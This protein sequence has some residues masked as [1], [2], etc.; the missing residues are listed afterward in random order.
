MKVLK[1]TLSLCPVCLKEI[2]ATVYEREDGIYIKK[3]CDEGHG[4]WDVM[5]EPCKDYYKRTM[6]T[7]F[8]H[9][10]PPHFTMGIP[11]THECN[12]KCPFCYAPDRDTKYDLSRDKI[13]EIIRTF[14]GKHVTLTGGEPTMNPHLPEF[15][16]ATRDAGLDNCLVSNGVKLADKAYLQTLIDAGMVDILFPMYGFDDEIYK[17]MTGRALLQNRLTV[18]QNLID[19]DMPICLSFTFVRGRN[20]EQFPKVLEYALKNSDHVHQIR[21]RSV[22]PGGACGS[23]NPFFISEYLDVISKAFDVTP[24]EMIDFSLGEGPYYKY[25]F[26]ESYKAPRTPI[27]FELQI[28]N[29]MRDRAANGNKRCQELLDLMPKKNN[30]DPNFRRRPEVFFIN[31][32]H[33]GSLETVDLMNFRNMIISLYSYNKGEMNFLEATLLSGRGVDL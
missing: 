20:E 17:E 11:I 4:K 23:E 28:I 15:I 22:S 24:Q 33:W 6:Q 13:L 12:L 30:D 32:W 19:A 18:L 10:D 8:F 3:E 2:P 7:E 31:C 14:R 26:P 9:N 1:E 29:F 27:H 16:K 5:F 25:T 21:M